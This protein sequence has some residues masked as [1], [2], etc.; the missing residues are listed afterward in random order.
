MADVSLTLPAPAPIDAVEASDTEVVKRGLG[1]AAWLAI[2]WLAFIVVI[3]ILAPVLPIRDPV[4]DTLIT[5]AVAN[6]RAAGFFTSGHIFGTDELGRD[7]LSST[8]WGAQA[9]LIIAVLAI[10]FGTLIG[11]AVGL[12]AGY[13]RGRTGAALSA[14]FDILLAFPPLLLALA[15]VSVL[16]PIPL[17]GEPPLTR[18]DRIWVVALSVGLVSIPIL[19]RI[20]RANALAWSQREFVLAAKAQGAKSGRVMVR[21]VLPNVVPAMLSISLLGVATVIVI[22]G[23]LALF[24]LSINP[25]DP[26]WGNMIASQIEDLNRTP[27]VWIVPSVVIFITVMALNFLGDVVRDRF[28]VREAAI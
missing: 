27:W 9:S 20:T 7:T 21:E 19:A 15:L 24:G 18:W 6:P 28:S 13:V 17:P 25:P 16:T 12:I 3:A 26:S 23:G 22:E 2:G 10:G 5:D 4:N 14:V 11:G 1:V 8:I